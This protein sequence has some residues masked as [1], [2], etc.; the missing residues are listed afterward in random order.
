MFLARQPVLFSPKLCRLNCALLG[1]LSLLILS[2]KDRNSQVFSYFQKIMGDFLARSHSISYNK[3]IL[4][5][6]LHRPP[7]D[8]FL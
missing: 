7:K 2:A 1:D 5:T 3:G 8:T 6:S 4:K